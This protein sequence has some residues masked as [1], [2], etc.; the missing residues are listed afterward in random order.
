METLIFYKNLGMTE[1]ELSKIYKKSELYKK[2]KYYRLY[3]KN[4]TLYEIEQDP[5]L[6]KS[7]LESEYYINNKKNFPYSI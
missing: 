4:Y 7:F 6:Y 1:N 3:E 5:V 2:S